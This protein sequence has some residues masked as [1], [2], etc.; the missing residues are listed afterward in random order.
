VTFKRKGLKIKQ[1]PELRL[2]TGKRNSFTSVKFESRNLCVQ[3][4]ITKAFGID[5]GNTDGKVSGG[6]SIL[7]FKDG[8]GNFTKGK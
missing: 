4:W 3:L 8:P 5:N 7:Y 6:I 2:Q 1:L